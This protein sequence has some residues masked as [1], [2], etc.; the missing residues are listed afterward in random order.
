MMKRLWLLTATVLVLALSSPLFAA[1]VQYDIKSQYV[2]DKNTVK[3]TQEF[4]LSSNSS[5][6]SQ[7]IRLPGTSEKFTVRNGAENVTYTDKA[8]TG[9][10]AG[11][12]FKAT[13]LTLDL[14]SEKQASLVINY[15]S[16]DLF[17]NYVKAQSLFAPPFQLSNI[18]S[19]EIVLSAEMELAIGNI[20]GAETSDI[21]TENNQ[22]V[23]TFKT[24]GAF[25]EPIILQMGAVANAEVEIGGKL[26]NDSFWWQEKT[27]VLPLDTNQQKSYITSIEPKPTS[28]RVDRDG[29]IIAS[30]FLGPK[31]G[32][33]VKAKAN[34]LLEQK[35]YDLDAAGGFEQLDQ[36]IVADYTGNTSLWPESI[37]SDLGLNKDELRSGTVMEAVSAVNDAI[38][39]QKIELT[40]KVDFTNR[41]GKGSRKQQSSLDLADRTVAALRAA[42]IPARVIGGVVTDTQLTRLDRT[43]F[44]VWIEVFVPG[45]GW[46]TVDP[47][48]N[49]LSEN[50]FGQSGLQRIALFI[51]G[52]NDHI[53]EFQADTVSVKYVNKA[54]PE[55]KF[56]DANISGTNY[57]LLPGIS[58]L[59]TQVSMPSG[60]IHDEVGINANGRTNEL[61][62]LAPLQK[63]NSLQLL[64]GDKSWQDIPL[65]LQIAGE[66]KAK[67]TANISVLSTVIVVVLLLLLIRLVVK[68]Y[69]KS[70]APLIVNQEEVTADDIESHNMLHTRESSDATSN[71]D[72]NDAAESE[73]DDDRLRTRRPPN[74][75]NF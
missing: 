4:G 6:G 1:D 21:S 55:E 15:K 58:L 13:D 54:Q 3:V 68:L 47:A 60:Y 16:K 25:D 62:S 71:D 28:V 37:L 5:L 69:K 59:H 12:N 74:Q 27:I 30:Y 17:A 20:I 26:Q 50:F 67:A 70:K 56:S 29:N 61:G 72:V 7:T 73:P 34:V 32:V 35:S 10:I 42:G 52:V 63:T 14:G 48:L 9:N 18:N 22:Q 8:T 33:D 49:R 43:E 57:I 66:T 75:I 41:I 24:S 31:Q 51:W 65:K 40:S 36:D 45:E 23:Y 11:I 53:P 64:I 38:S 39:K 44:Q 19:Q 2:L 46:M